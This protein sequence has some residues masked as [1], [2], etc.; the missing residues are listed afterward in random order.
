M[1][2]DN[3]YL[4]PW[5]ETVA[6]TDGLSADALKVAAALSE[7]IIGISR[8]VFTDWRKLNLRLGRHPGDKAVVSALRELQEARLVD[9][10]NP[11]TASGYGWKLTN[12]SE[13]RT[14]PTP[15]P[16]EP[17]AGA[18]AK[19]STGVRAKAGAPKPRPGDRGRG[20]LIEPMTKRPADKR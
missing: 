20:K 5:L 3:E 6:R 1:N 16:P 19:A 2:D 8:R 4:G 18:E 15:T 11:T 13:P 14:T 7:C 12:P 9:R 10:I 17:K